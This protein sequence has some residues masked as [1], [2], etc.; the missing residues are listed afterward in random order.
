M[1]SKREWSDFDE[2]LLWKYWRIY[3]LAVL[4]RMI[5]HDKR[6]MMQRAALMGLAPVPEE[7]QASHCY[8][9]RH[10]GAASRRKENR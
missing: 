1:G 5:G 7:T 2:F 4:A 9:G 3:P 8:V 6:A 10:K